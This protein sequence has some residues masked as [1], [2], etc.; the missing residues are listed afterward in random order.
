[1]KAFWLKELVTQK[2]YLPSGGVAPFEDAGGGYGILACENDALNAELTKA[3]KD[4]IGGVI[5]LQESEYNEWQKKKAALV[6]S[7]GSLQQPRERESLGPI[8]FQELQA[9]RAAGAAGVLSGPA[10][11]GPNLINS[12]SQA[13]QQAGQQRVEPITVPT[14][15]SKP[16]VGKLPPKPGGAPLP[17]PATPAP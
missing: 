17:P 7:S 3:A 14:S 4:H 9:I 11:L 15:F 16:R 8:P 12:P 13:Q 10:G 2:L 5:P 6:S 1:M